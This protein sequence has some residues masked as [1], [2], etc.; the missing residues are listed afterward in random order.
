MKIG[1]GQKSTTYNSWLLAINH[2]LTPTG[3]IKKPSISTLAQWIITA[4]NQITPECIIH[5]FKK[6]CISNSMDGLE[7]DVLWEEGEE[8][9]E[10][11]DPEPDEESEEV[12][13]G[14]EWEDD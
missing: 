1:H 11:D 9:E 3:K 4:W 14:E 7:D 13:T 10:V 5:G 6:C 8:V 12:E 2:A